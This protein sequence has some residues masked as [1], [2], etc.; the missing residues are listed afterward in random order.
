VVA[1]IGTSGIEVG[2]GDLVEGLVTASRLVNRGGK[3]I[4]LSHATGAIGPS[5]SRLIDLEDS[6]N[7]ATTL[8]GHDDD[9]DS[10][11]GR[12]LAQVLE[13][14]DVYLL[15]RLDSQTV[16]DLSMI[17]LE[18]TDDV[19]RLVGRSSSC[20]LVNHANLTRAAVHEGSA[21]PIIFT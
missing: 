18:R 19:R 11:A 14:A 9:P 16:E 15:S 6:R 20:L 10:V 1:G 12:R 3:I 2:I 5:L 4:A 8:R 21:H 17:P 13:L 7:G